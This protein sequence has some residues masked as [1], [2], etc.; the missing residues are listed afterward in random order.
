MKQ[1]VTRHKTQAE[2]NKLPENPIPMPKTLP[3]HPPEVEVSPYL[4]SRQK[5]LLD[6]LFTLI[7]L[8][9]VLL[10]LSFCALAILLTMGFPLIFAQNRV[11]IKG[12]VFMIYKLRTLKRKASNKTGITHTNGD[13]TP[14]GKLLRLFRFDELP[15]IW[16]IL[17]GEMSWVGPRPEVPYYTKKYTELNPGFRNR[18]LA[19]PGITGL[20]QLHNPNATPSDNPVKLEFDLEYISSASLSGDIYILFKTFFLLWK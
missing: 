4:L 9:G 19:L 10:L 17:R 1:S 13:I 7:V 12:K 2:M 8:P 18:L 6:L 3:L 16:N 15:Q 14:L 5:R 11:G 20:A